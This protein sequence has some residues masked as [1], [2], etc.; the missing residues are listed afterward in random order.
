MILLAHSAI[1]LQERMVLN[2]QSKARLLVRHGHV[3]GC[4]SPEHRLWA[5]RCA[6]LR[7]RA[8]PRTAEADW[9]TPTDE[10]GNLGQAC[11]SP[12]ASVSSF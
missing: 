6:R 1:L 3:D 7:H 10:L 5:K 8:I 11:Q 2:F 9:V 4:P 12:P